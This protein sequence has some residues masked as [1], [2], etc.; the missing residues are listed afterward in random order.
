MLAWAGVV[1]AVVSTTASALAAVPA[2]L[3]VALIPYRAEPNYVGM[4]D[5]AIGVGALGSILWMS[6]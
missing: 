5:A 1:T 3:A 4:L 6:L 2:C